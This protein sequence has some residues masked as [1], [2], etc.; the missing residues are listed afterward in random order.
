MKR[1]QFV[2]EVS[3]YAT[4]RDLWEGLAVTYGSG[5]EPYQVYDL[6]RQTGAIKQDGAILEALWNRFQKLWISIGIHEPSPMEGEARTAI[7]KYNKII[8]KQRLYQF[9]TALDDRF[10]AVKKEIIRRDP[11]PTARMAYGIVR[12]ESTNENIMGRGNHSKDANHTGIGHGLAIVDRNRSGQ[13]PNATNRTWQKKSEDNRSR[14]I[15]T[16][17]VGNKHTKEG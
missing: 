2:N 1:E 10:E 7:D 14:L 4:T 13:P 11:L 9:V 17:C 3:Q 5:T 6:H 16:H 15:C 8:Q 12:R